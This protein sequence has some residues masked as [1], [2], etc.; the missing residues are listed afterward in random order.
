MITFT[1]PGLPVSQPRQRHRVV[2]SYVQNYTPTDSPVNAFK[3]A[4]KIVASKHLLHS[5]EGP[6]L[7][8]ADFYFPRPKSMIWKSKLMVSEAKDTKPDV[9]NLA[10]SLLDALNSLGRFDDAQIYSLHVRKFIV[11]GGD[12]P[13]TEVSIEPLH[14]EV[15]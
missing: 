4:V 6:V 8:R 7:L 3:A 1:I 9:D 14:K 5:I 12:I 15:T 11:H 13:R 10:K 2:G